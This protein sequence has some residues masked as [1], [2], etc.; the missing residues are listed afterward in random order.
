MEF[1]MS[2]IAFEKIM[3]GLEDAVAYADGDRSKGIAHKVKIEDIDVAKLRKRL[4]LSQ[5]KFAAIFCISAKTVKNWEQ[6]IRHPEGP[7]RVLLQ[8]INVEP[9]LVMKALRNKECPECDYQFKGKGFDG[10]DAHWRAKHEHIMPYEKAWPLI[11][12]GTYGK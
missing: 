9:E 10:I 4:G 5:D 3:A 2:K 7:A 6:G 12:S 1:E 11:K 8:V